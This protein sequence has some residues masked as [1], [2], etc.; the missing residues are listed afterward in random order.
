VSSFGGRVA[1]EL[2]TE[3]GLEELDEAIKSGVIATIPGLQVPP[4]ERS[5]PRLSRRV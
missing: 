2:I 4:E 5:A 3:E 1:T